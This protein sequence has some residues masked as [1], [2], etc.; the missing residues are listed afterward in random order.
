MARNTQNPSSTEMAVQQTQTMALQPVNVPGLDA[1]IAAAYNMPVLSAEEEHALAVRYHRR[2]DLVAAEQLVKHNLRHVIYIARGYSGYGLPLADLIQEGAIGLMKAVK[3]YN[4][5]REVRLIS[6]AVHAI[7]AEIH[8]FIIKN[9]RIVKIATTR[10]QR[11][12]FFKLRSMK[13][14]QE[15]EMSRAE[16]QD[17]AE[18]LDVKYGD[19][20]E[21]E[22]RMGNADVSFHPRETDDEATQAMAPANTLIEAGAD[23]AQSEE[24]SDWEAYKRERLHSALSELDE[25]SREIVVA[26]RMSEKKQTLQVLAKKFKVSMERVRQIESEAIKHLHHALADCR[27]EAPA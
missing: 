12:L 25:R 26:R 22:K 16:T 4:P 17:M 5:D 23:P 24:H 6:F 10:A 18:Q 11:K 9:W 15:S 21:M 19:V 8:E 27:S 2:N 13:K 3:R 20:V 7:K 14:S 1:Y